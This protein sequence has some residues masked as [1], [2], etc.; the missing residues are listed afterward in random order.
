LCSQPTASIASNPAACTALQTYTG[1]IGKKPLLSTQL[2]NAM[3]PT[4]TTP[5][6]LSVSGLGWT[7]GFIQ[8]NWTNPSASPAIDWVDLGWSTGTGYRQAGQD[9]AGTSVNLDVAGQT[10]TPTNAWLWMSSW[11]N[12]GMQQFSSEWQFQ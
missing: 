9:V 2:T 10:T 5:S 8:L 11:N 1:A 12:A 6:T 3:F 7:D 4:L